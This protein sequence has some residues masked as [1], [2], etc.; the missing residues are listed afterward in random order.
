MLAA[1]EERPLPQE[2][3]RSQLVAAIDSMRAEDSRLY[4]LLKTGRCPP[5]VLRAY[6][7]ATVVSAELFCAS[8]AEMVEKAPDPAS[9]MVLLEN[10]LEEEGLSIVPSSGLRSRPETSHP[11]L[12][13]RFARAVGASEHPVAAVHAANAGRD[14][15]ASG[16]W[17]GAI[18]HLLLGQE[19]HFADAAPA[20]AE[21]LEAAGV[22]RHDVAF[23]WVHKTADREHGE[24]ALD[25][26]LRTAT[27]RAEQER[28]I[29]E[30]R[31]GAE[32]WMDAHGG[33]VS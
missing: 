31:A 14:M 21:A 30:A 24:Q 26:V 18:A 1:I 29:S 10:L 5:K 32:A 19:L 13:R 27:T 4:R 22:A 7:E 25:I 20:M 28:C 16:D 17:V 23:F 3:F 15:L 6:A 2:E 9:R 8:L 33:R 11:S 12:A